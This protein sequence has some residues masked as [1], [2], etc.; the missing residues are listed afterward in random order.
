MIATYMCKLWGEPR[1]RERGKESFN[2]HG[3]C[4]TKSLSACYSAVAAATTGLATV[5]CQHGYDCQ[6]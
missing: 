6:H 1:D 5:K 4:A 3:H 2:G